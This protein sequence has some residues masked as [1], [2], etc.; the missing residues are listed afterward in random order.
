MVWRKWAIKV[1]ILIWVV[2][3][4]RRA[5]NPRSVKC[6][7][8]DG[9]VVDKEVISTTSIYFTVYMLLIAV[10][11]FL[12]SFVMIKYL[13]FNLSNLVYLKK[14]TPD[15]SRGAYARYHSSYHSQI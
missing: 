2:R 3:E 9:A 8:L 1:L 13:P 12:I 7:K 6:I 10:A 14:N 15:F 4:M 11:T 5:I